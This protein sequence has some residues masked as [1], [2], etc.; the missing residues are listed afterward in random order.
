MI[1]EPAKGPSIW[2][3]NHFH[4]LDAIMVHAANPNLKVVAKSDLASEMPPGFFASFM[5]RAFERAGFMWYNRGNDSTIRERIAA[6]LKDGQ[7]V[8][9]YSEGTT[10]RWGPPREMKAGAIDIARENNVPIQPVALR[11]SLPIGLNKED[12]TMRN[13]K[14]LTRLQNLDC[15]IMF[16][17]LV[18]NPTDISEIRCVVGG[19]SMYR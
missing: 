3:A 1:G 15:A 16:S 5:T 6:Q 7:S 9:I 18:Q 14:M 10:Q 2:V 17:D 12:N 13:A 19:V 11:Y 8:L 4:F